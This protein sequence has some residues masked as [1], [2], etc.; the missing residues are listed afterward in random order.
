MAT[1]QRKD[2]KRRAEKVRQRENLTHV[3]ARATVIAAGFGVS[4]A[5]GRQATSEA[6]GSAKW[7]RSN[8]RRRRRGGKSD[9]NTHAVACL[10]S[11]SPSSDGR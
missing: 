11:P 5:G 2:A 3:C 1:E 7:E 4:S 6:F 9:S 10:A 8:E